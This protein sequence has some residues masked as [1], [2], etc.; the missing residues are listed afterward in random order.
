MA[1]QPIGI[2]LSSLNVLVRIPNHKAAN[3]AILSIDL[4]TTY[5]FSRVNNEGSVTNLMQTSF[6]G[7]VWY[8]RVFEA[9]YAP[10]PVWEMM[11]NS[12][13]GQN[14]PNYPNIIKKYCFN[15]IA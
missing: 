6:Y 14:P 2:I 7:L 5:S 8:L 3:L 9:K 10:M 11:A 4:H 13:V 15:K 12:G 1:I